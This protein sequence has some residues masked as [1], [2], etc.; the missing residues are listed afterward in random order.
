MLLIVLVLISG[1]IIL[2]SGNSPSEKIVTPEDK[3]MEAHL[4][5]YNASIAYRADMEK[6]RLKMVA[7]IEANNKS[8]ADFN[9]RFETEKEE[10]KADYKR[11]IAVLE[12]MN[13]NMKKRLEDYKADGKEN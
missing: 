8:I 11:K 5:L 12:Q 4:D 6:Q 13:T 10:V 9:A 1:A 2:M 7:K 3:L